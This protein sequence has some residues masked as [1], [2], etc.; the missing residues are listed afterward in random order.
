MS[1]TKVLLVHPQRELMTREVAEAVR[2]V[3]GVILE[4]ADDP[5]AAMAKTSDCEVLMS[6]FASDQLLAAVPKLRWI[7]ALGSGVDGFVRHASLPPD[8]LLT[9]GAGIHAQP[10][11]EAIL[12]MM[13]ALARRLPEAFRDQQ[14]RR[15]GAGMPRLLGASE[16]LIIGVGAI[17]EAVG[18]KCAAFGARVIGISERTD[19]PAGFSGLYPRAALHDRL[20]DADFVVLTAP[21]SPATTG[22]IN[23][24]AL[25]RMKSSAYIVNAGRG[26][27]IEDADLIA[28]LEAGK[29]SGAALDVFTTEPLAEDSPYWELPNVLVTPHRAGYFLG[30]GEAI[31]K[32][33]VANLN[34]Y[35]SGRFESLINRVR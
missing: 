6:F 24:P 32:I 26:G 27:L 22:I 20:A 15:W 4:M 10:V 14:A 18:A 31:A 2:S 30:Y 12:A 21:L 35:R 28:A 19:S 3:D 1:S 34:H 16:V 23:A 11:S 5:V 9:S 33:A 17:G 25:E 13:L 7:Q 29:I 8:V